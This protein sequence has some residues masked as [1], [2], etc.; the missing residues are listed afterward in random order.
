MTFCRLEVIH[1]HHY[2]LLF[3]VILLNRR[4]RRWRPSL[5]MIQNDHRSTLLHDSTPASTYSYTTAKQ[6]S[7][8]EAK[9][10]LVLGCPRRELQWLGWPQHCSPNGVCFSAPYSSAAQTPTVF[11]SGIG[12]GSV[13]TPTNRA[14]KKIHVYFLIQKLD[15]RF[16][17]QIRL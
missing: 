16:K 13:T 9:A 14:Q 10:G 12:E 5:K 6:L 3:A 8:P 17:L 2:L 7:I 15:K 1:C 4:N 11:F